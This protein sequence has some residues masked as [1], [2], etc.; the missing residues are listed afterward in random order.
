MRTEGT[1]IWS[2]GGGTQSGAIAAL[3]ADGKLPRPDLCLM[4][5][6][7]RER[8]GTWPF[9]DGFIRPQLAKAG[10]DLT[11]I[12]ATQPNGEPVSLYSAE[13][14]ILL[15]GFTTITGSIGKLSP[16]CSGTWKRD[17][18]ER[19]LRTIGV[20]T[21]TQWLGISC[22]E[23]KRLRSQHRPW[24]KIAYPLIFMVRMWRV[25]C[26]QLIRSKGWVGPIPNS[27]CWMCAN[28]DDN[29]WQDM[30]RNWPDD[31]EQACVLEEEVQKN[32]PHFWLHPSCTPLRAVDFS[33]QHTMFA[34][35]GCTGGCF[36]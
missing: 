33:A 18:Q 1:Q 31:F 4:V 34:D 11:V 12:R 2:C 36:T 5:N 8:S 22:D 20:I 15:P 14:G 28:A 26:V 27:A 7:G 13:G 25:D 17:V 21:G 24:L 10:L 3:I 30:K 35:R 19:Y 32:D 16:F 29:E 9:V 6:T 23:L